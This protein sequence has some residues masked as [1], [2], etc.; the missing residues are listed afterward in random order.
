MNIK[1]FLYWLL[2][3]A[4]YWTAKSLGKLKIDRTILFH[5]ENVYKISKINMLK[6]RLMNILVIII[7][8][9]II[10]VSLLWI[11]SFLFIVVLTGDGFI[12]VLVY[13]G[14]IHKNPSL[15][16]PPLPSKRQ[17]SMDKMV[18]G[19]VNKIFLAYDKPFLNPEISEVGL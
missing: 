2:S 15:F 10:W 6:T 14:V 1:A 7:E 18:F 13:L 5:I 12:Y 17:K 9:L 19:V 4:F 8:L 3:W 11:F 16:N